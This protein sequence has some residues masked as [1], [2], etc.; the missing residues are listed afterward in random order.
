MA[1][2]KVIV[3]TPRGTVF[4][5]GGPGLKVRSK[6]DWND[7]IKRFNG[8]YSRAQVWLD[9]RV[10]LDSNFYAPKLTGAMQKTGILGTTLGEGVVQWVSSYSRYLYYGKVMVDAATGQG[11]AHFVDKYG[12][13]IIRFRKGAK[14]R[15]T[16]EKL[17][18]NTSENPN[19]QAFWFEAAKA[20]NKSTWIRGVQAIAGG[21]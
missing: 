1:D 6:L 7:N 13:E 15:P 20:Q 17:K 5:V 12:N 8:Q 19:A 3:S 21:G 11:P 16:D 9:N 18:I 14:L 10:L 2:K 4:T